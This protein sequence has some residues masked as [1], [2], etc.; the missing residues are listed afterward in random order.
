MAQGVYRT[1][2]TYSLVLTQTKSLSIMRFL[3]L[4]L[5]WCFSL[6]SFA[7][8]KEKITFF[9]QYECSKPNVTAGDSIVV[10]VVLYCSHPFHDVHCTTKSVKIKGGH[11]RLITTRGQRQQ[12]Q[13][14]H[15]GSTYYAVVWERY[16]VG[17]ESVGNISFA[18]LKFE[19]KFIVYDSEYEYEPLD[20][21]GFFSR[22]T[23]KSHQVDATCKSDKFKLPVVSRPKRSTQEIISS[24]GQVA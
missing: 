12:Q 23:R 14:R 8:S 18:S 3:I 20:P 4:M 1:C 2:N 7:K 9:A 24:G 6:T 13:V 19:G 16:V 5:I 22:P 10:S 15:E 17:S 21:F 11:S